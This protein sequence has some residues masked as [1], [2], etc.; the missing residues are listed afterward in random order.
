MTQPVDWTRKARMSDAVEL[1]AA[2]PL[3]DDAMADELARRLSL[4]RVRLASMTAAPEAL[5]RVAEKLARKHAALPLAVEGRHLILAMANP[6]DVVAQQDFEF[7]SGLHIKPVVG[8]RAEILDAIGQYYAPDDRI[9]EFVDQVADTPDFRILRFGAD[10][11]ETDADVIE[12]RAAAGR[13]VETAPVVKLCN[14]MVYDAVRAAASDIHVEP[15]VNGVLVRFRIDGVLRQHTRFPKWLHE[16]VVSRLKIL[17]RLDIA[18]RRVPQDGRLKVVYQGRGLDLRVSTLP[19]HYGEKV[20]LRV[21]GGGHVPTLTDLG[22]PTRDL[23]SIESVIARAQGMVLVT[24][25]TGSG[26][27]TSLYSMLERV[28]SGRTE[29]RHD[30]RSD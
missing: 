29:H 20:V 24:G 28:R 4:R 17:A 19:T 3:D 23:E 15:G 13:G 27:T 5:E 12:T 1:H 2:A 16:P 22:L 7:A 6:Q 10:L 21:L 30:R 25:P 26:K 8:A 14:L 18:E 9:R 11:D